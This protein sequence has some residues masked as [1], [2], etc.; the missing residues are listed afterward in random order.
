MSQHRCRWGILGTAD[1]AKKNWKAIW[2]SGNATVTAVASRDR[3]RARAFVDFC[4]ELA[5]MD[6]APAA[7]GNYEELLDSPDVDAVYLPLPTGVRQPWAVAAARAGKHVLLEKPCCVSAVDL[8][9]VVRVCEANGVQFMDGV[10]FM[11]SA[12]TAALCEVLQD[13]ERIGEVRH[14]ASAVSFFGGPEFQAANIRMDPRLEPF[15]CLGDLG[16]Y[17]IRATLL[18]LDRRLP[19]SVSAHMHQSCGDSPGQ[20]KVPLE[21]TAELSFDQGVSA[22]FYCSFVTGLQEWLTIAGTRGYV[23]CDDFMLPRSSRDGSFLSKQCTFDKAGLEM[24]MNHVDRHVVVPEKASGHPTAQETKMFRHFSQL[25]LDG[26]REQEWGKYSLATQQ[27][28][29]ACLKSALDDGTRCALST[30]EPV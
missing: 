14:V 28:L 3:Q 13:A 10:M 12:R 20:G 30:A 5:P 9:E 2:Q 16:W 22:S 24:T 27:V 17:C 8:A 18:A 26:R 19:L 15:G 6:I 7:V 25:V 1:I 29:D 23:H 4:Q 11:H 21:L